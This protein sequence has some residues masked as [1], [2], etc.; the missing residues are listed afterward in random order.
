MELLQLMKD[1]DGPVSLL[2]TGAIFVMQLWLS[3][4]F[5]SKT[6]LED[7]KKAVDGR[8]MA[9]DAKTLDQR[10]DTLEGGVALLKNEIGHLPTASTFMATQLEIKEIHGQ[11]NVLVERIKPIYSTT[12]RMQD[13]LVEL[14]KAQDGSAARR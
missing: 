4:K 6:D 1:Y 2:L 7:L 9:A 5:A 3:S 13:F 10:L 14:S 12:E 11:M 8:A